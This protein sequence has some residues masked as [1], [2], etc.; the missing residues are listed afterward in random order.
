MGIIRKTLVLALILMVSISSVALLT[1]ESANAQTFESITIKDDGSFVPPT[2]SLTKTGNVYKLTADIFGNIK[3]EKFGIVLDGAGF[4]LRGNNSGIGIQIFNPNNTTP[5]DSFDVTIKNFKINGFD[6]GIDV[7]G[8]WGD[9]ISG[10]SI[11]G[12]NIANNSIGVLFSSYSRCSNNVI[13]GNVIAGNNRGIALIMG[14]Y[15]DESGNVVSFNQIAQNQVGMYFRWSGDY[16]CW[17]PNP[18]QMNNR[19]Y[20]NNFIDNN[21]N[22][23]NG[24]IIY[25]PDCANIWDNGSQSSVFWS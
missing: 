18:F 10:V 12:N 20:S 24:H 16:Y 5:I 23:V 6:Q 4:S 9:T 3:V 11:E 21:Q 15:G 19:I 22:V 1:A 25:D 13:I 14:H 2:A 17:K 8:Y 7:L